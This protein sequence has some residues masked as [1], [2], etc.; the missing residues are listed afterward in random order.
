MFELVPRGPFSLEASAAFLEGFAPAAH[1]A[2]TAGHLHLAFVPDGGRPAA[3]ICLRQPEATVIGEVFG[4]ADPGP[5][6]TRSHGSCPVTSTATSRPSWSC[7]AGPATPT[8]SPRTS[9]ACAAGRHSP[10]G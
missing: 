7:S 4:E 1:Q 8:T 9:R 6:R 3:G 2:G 10:T 5:C